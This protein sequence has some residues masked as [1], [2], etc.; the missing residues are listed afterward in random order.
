L[1]RRKADGNIQFLGRADTQVKIRGFRIELGEIETAL[2]NSPQVEAVAVITK[3][4]DKSKHLVAYYSKAQTKRKI[5]RIYDS[6]GNCG[7][8]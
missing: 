8:S 5:A 7:S 6:I 4:I 2:I 1:A 3:E